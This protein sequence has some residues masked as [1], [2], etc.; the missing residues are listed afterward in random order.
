[1]GAATSGDSSE[2]TNAVD[3]WALGCITHE[4]LTQVLPFPNFFVLSQY[5]TRPE[6]PRNTM[7]SKNISKEGIEFVERMLALLSDRRIA[8]KEAL[9]SE[10]LRPAGEGAAPG[11]EAL[12]SAGMMPEEGTFPTPMGRNSTSAASYAGNT[13]GRNSVGEAMVPTGAF[14]KLSLVNAHEHHPDSRASTEGSLPGA[15]EFPTGS[16]LGYD[17]S[18]P[19]VPYISTGENYWRVGLGELKH[20]WNTSSFL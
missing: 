20:V 4:M 19:P 3:I 14:G 11:W 12:H 15:P 16:G 8:A 18:D 2:Y 13:M 5:C 17:H 7:I 6:F 10:W 9:D 1:M